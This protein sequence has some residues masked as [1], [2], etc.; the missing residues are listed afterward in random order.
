[1][2]QFREVLLINM[3]VIMLYQSL[4]GVF[5]GYGSEHAGAKLHMVGTVRNGLPT[6]FTITEAHMYESTLSYR[7]TNDNI[8]VFVYI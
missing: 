7:T 4:L 3:D 6:E 2:E 5:P 1:M 8:Y